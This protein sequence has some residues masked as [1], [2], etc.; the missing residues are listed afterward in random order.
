[1]Q[2]ALFQRSQAVNHEHAL[3]VVERFTLTDADHIKYEATVTDPKV[4]SRPWKINVVL[5]RRTEANMQVLEYECYAFDH[6]F[7]APVPGGN[8]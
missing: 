4:F 7:H 1:M 5:Y 2:E 8:R 3:Q 6:E